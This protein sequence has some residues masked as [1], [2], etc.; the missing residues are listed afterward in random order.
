MPWKRALVLATPVGEARLA[1][2]RGMVLVVALR[3][4]SSTAAATA[5]LLPTLADGIRP[6]GVQEVA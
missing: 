4:S 6:R 3:E 2:R 5:T 1:L